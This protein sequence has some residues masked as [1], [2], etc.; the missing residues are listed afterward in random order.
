MPASQ[1]ERAIEVTSSLGTDVFLFRRMVVT[2]ALGRPFE[3]DLEIL[4]RD[5]TI[6]LEDVLGQDMTISLELPNSETRY[7]NGLVSRFSYV[8]DLE[9]LGLYHATLHP[10]LWFLTRTADCRIF[11]EE[12]VPDIVKAVFREHGYTDF[13]E[14]LNQTHRVWDYCVQYRETDFNFV[15]RLMEQEGIYY[16]F[17]HEDGRHILVLSDSYNSHQR[18]QGYERVPYFPLAA[19]AIRERDHIS[20][21]LVRQEI[22]SGICA[23]NDFDFTRP[24]ADLTVNASV[25]REHRYSEFE[26]YDYPGEYADTEDGNTYARLRIEELHTQY[27]VVEGQGNA[28]GLAAGYLFELTGYP[29]VDQEREYLIVSATHALESDEYAST[30]SAGSQTIYTCSFTAIDSKQPFKP[31]RSTPKPIV[32][33]PQTAMVVGKSEEEIDTDKYGRVKVQFHW[34]RNGQSDEHS[35]CW[36]RVAQIWAGNRWGGM[37]IPR[38]GQEVLVDFLEGDPDRPIITG[39]V[40][41]ADSMPPYDLPANK[42]RSTIKSNSSKGG[43]GS[44]EIRFE[45][46]KG[47][48]QFFV[49]AEKDMDKRVKHD[50]REF[51]GN[52]QHIIVKAN[53]KQLIEADKHEHVQGSNRGKVDGDLSLE[54]GGKRDEKVGT[55]YAVDAGQEIHLKGGMNVILEAGMQL[56]IKGAGGFVNIGPDGI[57]IQGTLVKIN[58]GGAAGTGSGA[59]PVAPQP[60]DE[61]DDY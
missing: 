11:Q 48:E 40:Y 37:Y 43:G 60:P 35:S 52:D 33:G 49:H 26:L 3:A 55:I 2:E 58:S 13:E 44:N 45:D 36:I 42:T 1:I 32:Q 16:Y 18:F 6:R 22:Q 10:W 4:S 7:F 34:D 56:T 29:R 15:S 50:L 8:G 25:A 54:I 31:T 14:A 51:V 38:I 30:V 53:Q 17:K 23:L 27:E 20:G 5:D 61:A 41:N 9:R 12:T 24:K 39:R 47:E 28:R 21:W 46:K 19:D 57:T 59:S